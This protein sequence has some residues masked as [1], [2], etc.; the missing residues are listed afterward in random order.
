MSVLVDTSVWSLALRRRSEDLAPE[1]R[2]IVAEWSDLVRDGRLRVVGPIRQ[3]V[4]SGL[5][6]Q[7]QFAGLERRLSAF[8]DAPIEGVDY[9]QAARFFNLCRRHGVTG[10]PIDLLLCAV[11]HRFGWSIFARDTGF[12]RYSQL[13]PVR[14]H[15]IARHRVG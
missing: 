1:E 4:L 12:D 10:G 2:G 14:L 15:R 13:L 11:A 9:I 8:R 3:E 5:R 6:D 7:T